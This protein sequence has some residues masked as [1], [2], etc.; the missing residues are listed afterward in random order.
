MDR[1]FDNY[2][3]YINEESIDNTLIC[4]I[5]FKPLIEPVI[6]SCEN[7]FCRVCIEES[8][9]EHYIRC[10][11]CAK[12]FLTK[13]LHP[14]NDS[15]ILLIL[16]QLKIKCKLCNEMN[17]ERVLFSKH[18]Y[19]NCAK[20]I[21]TCSTNEKNCPWIGLREDLRTHLIS[22]EYRSS[23]FQNSIEDKYG[24]FLPFTNIDLQ[25]RP[26]FNHDIAIAVK[27]LLINQRCTCL[28]LFNKGISSDDT[29]TFAAILSNDKLLT[30]LSL[31]NNRL[32][33]SGVQFIAHALLTN[34][35]LKRLDLNDNLITDT[36]VCLLTEMLKTNQSLIKLTL[37]FNRISNEGINMLIDVLINN[38]ST[39]EWLCLAGNSAID[40]T[41]MHG[42]INL[43]QHNQSLRILNLEDCHLS[44]WCKKQII[45]HQ[46]IHFKSILDIL[47]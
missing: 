4:Q 42:I 5:C 19:Q 45:F 17:L 16:D 41:S 10:H 47:L 3:E 38:N 37:S 25:Q 29:F 9:D 39:L 28:D 13:Q 23:A 44:W 46:T 21:V 24:E 40:D 35:Y 34:S 2:Y 7:R 12:S 26:L 36:G 11:L 22:C 33:D 27:A 43:I 6:T 1:R 30:T 31:R 18:I 8:L 15:S 32:C 14:L 20:A